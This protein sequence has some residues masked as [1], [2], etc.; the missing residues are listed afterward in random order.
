MALA[1]LG[2]FLVFLYAHRAVQ[3]AVH[4]LY[5]STSRIRGYIDGLVFLGVSLV[6]VFLIYEMVAV[7]M[8]FLKVKP[9][10]PTPSRGE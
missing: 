6:E 5:P 4:G 7:F 2:A 10:R 8:P 1:H 3:N 9:R